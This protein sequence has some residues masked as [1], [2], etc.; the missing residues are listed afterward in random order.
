MRRVQ[1]QAKAEKEAAE[2]RAREEARL[3]AEEQARSLAR[4]F[5]A[6]LPCHLPASRLRKCKARI[7][8]HCRGPLPYARARTRPL[9]RNQAKSGGGARGGGE[10]AC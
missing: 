6:R 5:L 10:E 4:A 2:A 9:R 1:A 3:K 8:C 7:E